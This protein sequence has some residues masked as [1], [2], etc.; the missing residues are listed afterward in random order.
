[1]ATAQ[2]TIRQ[3]FEYRPGISEWFQITQVLFNQVT[4]FYFEVIQAHE[5]LLNLPNQQALT[6]RTDQNPNPPLPLDEVADQAPAYFRRAAI[7][8]ALGSARSFYSNLKRW[9]KQKVRFEEKGKKFTHRP[10]VPPRWWN[11]TTVFYQG[12]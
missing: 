10:P 5:H 12:M 3:L 1:M 6:H 7:N 11:K 9:R 8:A 2:K 4:H